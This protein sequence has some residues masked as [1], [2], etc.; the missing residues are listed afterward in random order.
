MAAVKTECVDAL[1]IGAGLAGLATAA[2]LA[3]AGVSVKVLEARGRTGG[4]VLTV[5]PDNASPIDLGAQFV[6]PGHRRVR[7]LARDAGLTLIDATPDQAPMTVIDAKG[8]PLKRGLLDRFGEAAAIARFAADAWLPQQGPGRLDTITAAQMLRQWSLTP[9]AYSGLAALIEAELCTGLETISAHEL[10]A[11]MRSLGGLQAVGSADA[12]CIAEGAGALVEHLRARIDPAI[13]HDCPVESIA[14]THDDVTVRAAGRTYRARIVVIAIPPQLAARL[15]FNPPLPAHRQRALGAFTLGRIEKT[16]LE[17]DE[18]WWVEAGL[19]GT[20]LTPG[21]RFDAILPL[22]ARADGRAELVAFS[23]RPAPEFGPAPERALTEQLSR[24][25]GAPVPAPRT[26][27]SQ[28]WSAEP[29]SLGGYASRRAPGDW[30][31]APDLFEPLDRIL[32]AGT[33]TARE[34]RSFMEGALCSA[35]AAAHAALERLSA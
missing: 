28:N 13:V 11:Q 26:A 22:A 10:I 21:G 32:F 8:Q 33:E 9:A 34:W 20:L 35:E 12:F 29:Y 15:S 27:A 24:V 7:T 16:I 23:S 1:I 25:L 30:I 31:A 14:T 2:A 3:D 17:F 5:R 19:A 4:R 6:A 18:P